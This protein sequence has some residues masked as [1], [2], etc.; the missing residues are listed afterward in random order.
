MPD[1]VLELGCEELPATFVRRAYEQ[2]AREVANRLSEA[3]LGNP[4]PECLGTPRRLLVHVPGLPDRQA[5]S[6]KIQRG[7][8]L[9]AAYDA[10]GQPTPALQGFCRSQGVDPQDLYTE[11]DYVWLKKH[12]AGRPTAELLPEILADSI[13]AL[14]FDKSMR[15][16]Q[17]RM[18]FARP[19]RWII[20][21]LDGTVIPF[22]IEGVASSNQSCGHRFYAPDR[23]E[24]T[25]WTGLLSGLRERFVEPDPRLREATI[26][27]QAAQV[28]NGTPELTADLVEENV[29][30]TE[31]PRA[32]QGSFK[33]DFAHLP[34]AVLIT[35]MAKHERF[36]P[37]RDD[38]GQL[39]RHFISIRNAG[40]DDPVR[41]GNEW[42]LNARFNDAKFFYDEDR[43]STLDQFLAKT[44]SMAFQEQLGSVRLRTD[45]LIEI[46][47]DC[48]AWAGLDGS[49]TERGQ[50]AARYAKADLSTGLVME[51]S[52]LQGVIGGEY[53]RREGL[54]SSICD[55]IAGQYDPSRHLPMDTDAKRLGI[56]LIAADQVDKLVGYLG[57][58][59]SPTGSS[60]PYGL[61]RA[62]TILIESA[63]GLQAGSFI[64]LF[65]AAAQ[66]Y[67]AQHHKGNFAVLESIAAILRSRYDAL[68]SSEFRY[69]VLEAALAGEERHLFDP[70]FIRFRCDVMALAANDIGFLQT[71]SRPI[72]IVAAAR[73][74]GLSWPEATEELLTAD[75]DSDEGLQLFDALQIARESL[76]ASLDPMGVYQSLRSLEDPVNAFF[77]AAMVMAD[78]ERVRNARLSLLDAVSETILRY[79]DVSKIVVEG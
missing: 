55:A 39:T 76:S 53:A 62:V 15:W 6:E 45:R 4:E 17:S 50:L 74:K 46:M 40:E 70:V 58:G 51:L 61:R 69:D 5:D 72:N 38:S 20:A 34:D 35:A 30:L 59:L 25:D 7:P 37:V 73:S 2:L 32:I 18:R 71:A 52:S 63:W 12:V 78:Q 60:D 68:L 57:V 48:L 41:D 31:W 27:E 33:E 19:I 36:F 23:F 26:R 66:R 54:D 9:K 65:G 13:R 22:D 24:V 1:L 28:A 67:A 21:L 75:V 11:G 3:G 29:F 43:K 44:E 8:G 10:S 79:G 49:W 16:G 56:A 77:S 64:G 42:V 14:T 47:P